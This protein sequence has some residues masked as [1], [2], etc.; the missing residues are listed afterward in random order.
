MIKGFETV[1][2]DRLRGKI[3][4]EHK[5]CDICGQPLDPLG[6]FEYWRTHGKREVYVHWD[7]IKEVLLK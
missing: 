3:A 4:R 5:I 1:N 6:R 2:K 7:C